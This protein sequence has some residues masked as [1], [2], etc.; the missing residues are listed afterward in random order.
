LRAA[1]GLD[2][3]STT[4]CEESDEDKTIHHVSLVDAADLLKNAW[5]EQEE[6]QG[7][8]D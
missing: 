1:A 8:E 5:D 3:C 2:D 4:D 7:T 6:G